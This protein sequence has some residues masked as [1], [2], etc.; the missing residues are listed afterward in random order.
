MA[1][2][3]MLT[4]PWMAPA[5]LCCED[6]LVTAW[7]H[8]LPYDTLVPGFL[9]R[10]SW[11]REPSANEYSGTWVLVI[12]LGGCDSAFWS[13]LSLGAYDSAFLVYRGGSVSAPG[14]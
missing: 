9:C 11:G 10:W 3:H 1:Q 8:W 5:G 2:D 12:I 7:C 4:G 14:F 6:G 13:L